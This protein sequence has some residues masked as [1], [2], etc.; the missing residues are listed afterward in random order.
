[1]KISWNKMHVFLL[2]LVMFISIGVYFGGYFYFISPVQ[3]KVATV[4][5]QLAI[6][7]QIIANTD[8]SNTEVEDEQPTRSTNLQKKLP[9]EKNLDQL[10][11]LLNQIENNTDVTIQQIISEN[12]SL[13]KTMTKQLTNY[14]EEIESLPMQIQLSSK[15]Q[16]SLNT[17]LQEL[18]NLERIVNIDVIQIGAIGEKQMESTIGLTAFYNPSLTTLLIEAPTFEYDQQ[19]EDQ[20]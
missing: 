17:F 20:D 12:T 4:S 7:E 16:A 15:N 14:S 5:E 18:S 10:L 9:V 13:N 1:M 8:L 2:V 6:Q 11:L 3:S 19:E